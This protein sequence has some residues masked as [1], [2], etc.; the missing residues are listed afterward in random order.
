M[1]AEKPRCGGAKQE[2][3]SGKGGRETKR[4]EAGAGEVEKRRHREGVVADATMGKQITDVGDEGFVAGD[5]E[6]VDQ[7]DGD[8]NAEDREDGVSGGDP[9]A[10]GAVWRMLWRIDVFCLGESGGREHEEREVGREGVVLLISREREE[11]Q[12]KGGEQS[13]EKSGALRE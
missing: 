7:S 2:G 8:G 11:H 10:C 12:D 6:A 5:P 4:G 9:A 1:C 13:E 3:D